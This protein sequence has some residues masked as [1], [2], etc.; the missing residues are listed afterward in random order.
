MACKKAQGATEYLVVFA[1]VLIVAMV[2]VGLL[3]SAPQLFGQAKDTA[4]SI[5]W[6]STKP[7]QLAGW[8]VRANGTVS[9][10]VQNAGMGPITITQISFSRQADFAS[11]DNSLPLNLSLSGGSPSVYGSDDAISPPYRCASG[12]AYEY[13]VRF[14]YTSN[15]QAGFFSGSKPISGRCS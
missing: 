9:L 10:S 3:A 13:Y 2:A 6:S 11:P 7:I 1:V 14:N 4:S 15:G 8:V 12:S 5:Y